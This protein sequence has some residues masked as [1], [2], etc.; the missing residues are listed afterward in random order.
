M[1]KYL[2]KT[3]FLVVCAF[4]L[5]SHGAELTVKMLNSGK[6]G[7]MVFEPAVLQVSVGDTV[8]FVATDGGHNSASI[9]GLIPSGAKAW[10]GN[11]NQDIAVKFDK[12]GVYVY[13]CTP[14][15]VLAMV[16]VVVVGDA[17]NLE[18]IKKSSAQ[19]Q[20]TFVMNKDRLSSYLAALK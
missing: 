7:S 18:E 12:E 1:K 10:Q 16:G 3:L 2:T 11:L 15:V 20:K 19:I 14:H 17:T 6:N 5:V 13:Q 9:P 4:S 8:K